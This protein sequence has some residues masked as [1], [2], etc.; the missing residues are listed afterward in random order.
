MIEIHPAAEIFPMLSTSKIGDLAD[1]IAS[2]GLR[3][4]I[5]LFE[6]KLLDGRNRL[7]ACAIAGVDPEFI[8]YDGVDPVGFVTSLNLHRRHLSSSQRA[9][10]AAKLAELKQGGD[11]RS[12][13]T[14][15]LRVETQ[16]EA[17]KKLN[18][19]ER[20]VST[21]RRIIKKGTPELV[22]AVASGEKSLNT[23]AK[24]ITMPRQLDR[25]RAIEGG[26]SDVRLAV[27]K[28]ERRKILERRERKLRKSLAEEAAWRAEHNTEAPVEMFAVDDIIV[29]V[30]R[31]VELGDI[32][33]LAKSIDSMCLI[34]AIVITNDN[35]LVVG[36]RRLAAVKLLGWDEIPVCVWY[37][38]SQQDIW[39]LELSENTC[40]LDYTA[41]ELDDA[42]VVGEEGGL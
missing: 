33:A 28:E 21:A 27:L 40:R 20:S 32:E 16:A 39:R 38:L 12:D 1:D 35:L 25:M 2:N 23:A 29:G 30:R 36:A 22:A 17:A 9:M 42:Q 14:A 11:R 24:I 7:A 41:D 15:N 4:P 6:G 13:Q 34:N 10:I 5:V 8:D 19:S 18:V 37:G 3:A 26:P 31:R